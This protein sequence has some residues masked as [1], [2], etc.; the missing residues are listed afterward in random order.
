[1]KRYETGIFR[2]FANIPQ[3]S[4][5]RFMAAVEVP[6]ASTQAPP[7]VGLLHSSSVV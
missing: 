7:L 3:K 5:A 2:P 6:T 4:E 1:M